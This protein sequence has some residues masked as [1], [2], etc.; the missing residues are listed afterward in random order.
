M[1]QIKAFETKEDC[2]QATKPERGYR[3]NRGD[4]KLDLRNA[5]ALV[6]DWHEN[7]QPHTQT[8][9]NTH[10]CTSTPLPLSLSLSP[11][12]AFK[13]HPPKQEQTAGFICYIWNTT[14]MSSRGTSRKQ[15]LQSNRGGGGGG[16][17]WRER[18]RGW[19]ANG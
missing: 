10:T 14:E 9:T 12:I 4:P 5:V 3:G 19:A 18:G 11:S 6:I 8:D 13:V 15:G 7:A 2:C 1:L 17:K 16:L